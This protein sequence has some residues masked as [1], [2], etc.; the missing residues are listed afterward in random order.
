[1]ASNL[2]PVEHVKEENMIG[3]T[4]VD[5]GLPDGNLVVRERKR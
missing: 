5:S 4:V 1:M 2:D 3:L